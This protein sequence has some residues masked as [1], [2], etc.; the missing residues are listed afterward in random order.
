L[1]GITYRMWVIAC[2]RC[3]DAYAQI[4]DLYCNHPGISL[5]GAKRHA[6]RLKKIC[7]YLNERYYR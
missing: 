4:G 6:K 7:D 1:D 2:K 3:E 5:D